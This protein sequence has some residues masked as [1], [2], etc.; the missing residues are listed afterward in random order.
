VP[1]AGLPPVHSRVVRA[2]PGVPGFLLEVAKARPH[3]LQI[4]SLTSATRPDQYSFPARSPTRRASRA[5]SPSEAW[6]MEIDLDSEIVK[7]KNSGLCR[8]RR[9]AWIEAERL[10]A[11]SPP[12]AR[13]LTAALAGLNVIPRGVLGRTAVDLAPDVVQVIPLA[14]RRRDRHPAYPPPADAAELGCFEM[15]DCGSGQPRTFMSRRSP[16]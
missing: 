9:A 3:G 6:K 1:L 10:R 4:M 7:S 14:Q 15:A 16:A 5:F 13:W 8:A 11:R 12:A 2:G